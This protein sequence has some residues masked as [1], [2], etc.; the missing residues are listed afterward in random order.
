MYPPFDVEVGDEGYNLLGE[1][2]QA[3]FGVA[4]AVGYLS[5]RDG[6]RLLEAAH[7]NEAIHSHGNTSR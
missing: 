5:D 6:C 3:A 7:E 2:R 4:R 1:V